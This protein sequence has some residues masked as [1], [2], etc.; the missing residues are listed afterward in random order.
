MSNNNQT[1]TTKR[2]VKKSVAPSKSVT[3]VSYKPVSSI[4]ESNDYNKFKFILGNRG[5]DPR[6]LMVIENSI[7]KNGYILNPIKV[8]KN[9][10]V[11]DGQHRLYVLK[12]LNLPVH[13]FIDENAILRDV[14]THNTSV[15]WTRKD[16]LKSYVDL[17][18]PEYIKFNEFWAK[19]KDIG[20]SN[21]LKLA[22]GLHDVNKRSK[23]VSV[24]KVDG[25]EVKVIK[26]FRNKAFEEG[27]FKFKDYERA[28]AL[29]KQLNSLNST[30][31]I[32]DLS[33]VGAF[34][35]CSN[36]PN[37]DFKRFYNQLK[38]KGVDNPNLKRNVDSWVKEMQNI[39][40]FKKPLNK[41]VMLEKI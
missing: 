30:F 11:I 2:V 6:N 3:N 7:K 13:Y 10:E 39:Y 14:Q 29:A 15:K 17:K 1:K 38:I 20:F 9:F 24:E 41:R 27:E 22:T 25:E 36:N 21:C 16:F 5:L 8:N 28:E 12:K 4:Y 35:R 37:F 18:Q 32:K 33:F 40:N 23:F 34:L 19:Y 26:N 31:P